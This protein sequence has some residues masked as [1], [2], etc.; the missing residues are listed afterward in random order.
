MQIVKNS[1]FVSPSDIGKL[2]DDKPHSIVF[3]PSSPVGYLCSTPRLINP[4]ISGSRF[5][6]GTSLL[7][8]APRPRRISD[9]YLSELSYN[10]LEVAGEDGTLFA[11]ALISDLPPSTRA[12]L[13]ARI[14]FGAELLIFSPEPGTLG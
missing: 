14:F 9:D 3:H 13:V 5:G 10:M 8:R 4:V 6:E 2:P 7:E 1:V 12:A 11:R